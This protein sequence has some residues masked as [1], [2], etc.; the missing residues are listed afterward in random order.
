MRKKRWAA[1][2][3]GWLICAALAVGGCQ[4]VR[5]A[6]PLAVTLS[7]AEDTAQARWQGSAILL[8]IASPSGIGGAHLTWAGDLGA[9]ALVLRLPLAG[10]E[11]LAVRNSASEATLS[12]SS[13]PPY[14]VRA[15]GGSEGVTVT[16]E[17]GGFDVRLEGAWLQSGSLD[18]EWIDFYR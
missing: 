10:L 9:E 6:P 3:L 5:G 17:D 11:G 15:E 2:W 7:K 12:V 14:T 4:P 8:E 16:R 1:V 13:S 18:V